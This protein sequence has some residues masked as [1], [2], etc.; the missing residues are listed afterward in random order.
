VGK[1]LGNSVPSFFKRL[2]A[3]RCMRAAL[4][5]MPPGLLCWPMM[6]EVDVDGMA[7]LIEP[8][9]QYS[10]TFCFHMTDGSRGAV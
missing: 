5:V 9:H 2:P 4:K 6:S 10:V 3:Q 8:S 7:V 1:D